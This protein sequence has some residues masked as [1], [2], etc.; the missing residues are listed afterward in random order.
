MFKSLMAQIFTFSEIPEEL[1]S[2]ATEPA[3]RL[4]LHQ[5][6]SGPRMKALRGRMARQ[7]A[8]HTVEPHSGLGQAIAN[9]QNHW[10]KLTLFLRAPGDPLDNNITERILENAI[11][12]RKKRALLS[13]VE[14]RAR[15]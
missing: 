4:L 1:W 13:D 6:E 15:R 9:M 8:E 3:E 7:F 14:R 11:Q 10:E 12:H 5:K 2:Q